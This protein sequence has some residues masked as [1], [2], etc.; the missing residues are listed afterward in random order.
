VRPAPRAPS[1]RITLDGADS[2][3][4]NPDYA[5]DQFVEGHNNRLAFAAAKAVA[6]APGQAYNPLF[7]HGGVGLGKTHLLQGICLDIHARQPDARIQYVSCEAFVTRYLEAVR[8]NRLL[9]FREGYRDLD[10]LVI[11]D[12]HFLTKRGHSQEEF[13]H[14]FNA[15]HQMRRQIVLS[16][17]APPED[18]PDLEARLVSRFKW[19]LVAKIEAPDYET[20]IEILRRKAELR[21]LELPEKVLAHI[22]QHHASNVRELEGAIVR[23]QMEAAIAGAPITIEM[24]RSA[25]G[26]PAPAVPPRP[27]IDAI[28]TAVADHHH[29]KRSDILGKRRHKSVVVPRQIAMYLARERTKHSLEEIGASFGGRDHTTVMHAHGR[30]VEL[31]GADPELAATI[32]GLDDHVMAQA[33]A[34]A[35]NGAGG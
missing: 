32:R 33:A 4:I 23:L 34:I 26:T 13:F 2:L 14:V 5:F 29:L 20:R 35:L 16:S 19:G 1:E 24:A 15:L 18:I 30:M 22:A 21:E 27:T 31:K 17:D 6:D 12:I 7:I 11:D 8:D 10:L 9:E 25:L 3:P 28:I